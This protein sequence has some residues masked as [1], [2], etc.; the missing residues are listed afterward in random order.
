M[1]TSSKPDN[2]IRD[3]E[4]K[5]H[6]KADD[7]QATKS[8]IVLD[9]IAESIN[10]D[11]PVVAANMVIK[12]NMS[13]INHLSAKR[14]S[15]DY[16]KLF[17]Q[18]LDENQKKFYQGYFK[19]CQELD[20]Q[21][22]EWNLSDISKLQKLK[23]SA[24][25]TSLWGQIVNR[26]INQKQLSETEIRTLLKQNDLNILS[27]APK[28]LEDYYL[29]VIHWEL[30][31]VLQNHQYEY[32]NHIRLYAHQLYLCDLGANCGPQ[33]SIM[34]SLCYLNTHS[35]GLDYPHYVTEILTAGQQAD[36]QLAMNYLKRIYQ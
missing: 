9:K 5:T 13:C 15:A 16:T 14:K 28:L 4:Q 17:E 33:S 32:T 29:N 26:E 35:C 23:N 18:K 7:P 3:L 34:A 31:D 20:K 36:I 6:K 19:Y 12:N 10:I 21:H 8:R 1:K 27:D 2:K 30:E 25:A 22:P 24:V 11:D